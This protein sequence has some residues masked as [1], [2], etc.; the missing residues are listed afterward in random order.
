[1]D[2]IWEQRIKA[3]D[4]YPKSF[5]AVADDTGE[6]VAHNKDFAKTYKIALRIANEQN[7]P[8]SV[9][10]KKNRHSAMAGGAK[11]II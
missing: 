2:K 10:S 6:I 8:I 11:I 3:Q 9:T 5:V 4:K 7:R 1:M